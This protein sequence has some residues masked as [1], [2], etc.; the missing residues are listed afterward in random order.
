[1]KEMIEE[2]GM[3]IAAAIG[4]V[5]IVGILAMVLIPNTSMN[6]SAANGN[7]AINYRLMTLCCHRA[8]FINLEFSSH[9]LNFP[10]LY[11][12]KMKRRIQNE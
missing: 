12:K 3:F 7:H 9:K 4:G 1:M 8:F 6:K 10:Y 5:V 2:Y 11:R